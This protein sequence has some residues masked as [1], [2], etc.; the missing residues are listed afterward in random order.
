MVSRE[1]YIQPI[2][3]QYRQRK[4]LLTLLISVLL[5]FPSDDHYTE[6]FH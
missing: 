2:H 4:R 1:L 3:Q 6:L 5:H